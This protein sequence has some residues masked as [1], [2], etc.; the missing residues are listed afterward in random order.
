MLISEGSFLDNR[1]TQLRRGQ[2]KGTKGKVSVCKYTFT[3]DIV[4]SKLILH[5]SDCW[6]KG[7]R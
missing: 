1:R 5:E 3:V 6:T 2:E 7:L 4:V